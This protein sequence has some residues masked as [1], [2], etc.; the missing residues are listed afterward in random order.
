MTDIKIK[1]HVVKELPTERPLEKGAVYK[2]EQPNGDLLTYTIDSSGEPVLER[3]ITN[4]QN[5]RLERM[6]SEQISKVESITTGDIDKLQN[7]DSQQEIDSKFNTKV[8]KESGKSLVSDSEIDKLENLKSQSEIDSD[9]ATATSNASSQL[10]VVSG[11]VL[12]RGNDIPEYITTTGKAEL[13]GGNDT[14]GKTFTN[15]G[16][17]APDNTFNVPKGSVGYAYYDK[18][19]DSWSLVDMGELPQQDISGF[20]EKGGYEG[21]AQ[22]LDDRID[23]LYYKI[24]GFSDLEIIDSVIWND[25]IYNATTNTGGGSG[26][27]L[28]TYRY[29]DPIDISNIDSIDLSGLANMTGFNTSENR[30][31]TW[32]LLDGDG[33]TIKQGGAIVTNYSLG[34][35]TNGQS[36]II[37]RSN[38]SD[39]E[40]LY[41]VIT[42]FTA[43]DTYTPSVKVTKAKSVASSAELSALSETVQDNTDNIDNINIILEGVKDKELISI[44]A[45]WVAGIRNADG[46]LS[47]NGPQSAQFRN[48]SFDVSIYDQIYLSGLANITSYSSGGSPKY[49]WTL[50]DG[51]G[52]FIAGAQIVDGGSRTLIM[53]DYSQHAVKILHV[54]AYQPTYN[55]TY[56]PSVI[57]NKTGIAAGGGDQI[58][59]RIWFCGDSLCS[60][61]I[62][63]LTKIAAHFDYEVVLGATMGG[64][65]TIGNLTRSGGIPARINTGFTIPATTTAVPID[66]VSSWIKSDNNYAPLGIDSMGAGT[67]TSRV[68]I[69]G[70]QGTLAKVSSNIVGLLLYNSNQQLI[71]VYSGEGTINLV[72]VFYIRININNPQNSVPHVT[73][74]GVPVEDSDPANIPLDI[75]ELCEFTGYV[76][77]TNS[78]V[79]NS[80]YLRSD[81]IAVPPGTTSI[82]FDGLAVAN[83]YT[84]TRLT[85]GEELKVGTGE[86]LIFEFFYLYK[87]YPMIV[88]TGQN[89]GYENETDLVE[90]I[91]AATKCFNKKVILNTYLSRA[92]MEAQRLFTKRFGMTFINLRDYMQTRSVGDA[93]QFGL[94]DDTSQQADWMSL[95]LSDNVHQMP[96]GGFVQA[97][98]IW[99][100]L[101]ELGYVEGDY[102]SD[103]NLY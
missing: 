53:S 82:Y 37:D 27:Q 72:D 95:L 102:V 4:E 28:D 13:L 93:I 55:D 35:I 90:Q 23:D 63:Q 45:T 103:G 80:A 91:N 66:L 98:L 60:A 68:R 5:A 89:G 52:D 64:E 50:F 33:V 76:S 62:A 16:K 78:V 49:T 59:K 97:V 74:L 32:V 43:T 83:G 11:T 2:V 47:N 46:G 40:E 34:N 69:K 38:Y 8:D 94:I 51:S 70:V 17:P 41:L 39:I 54:N 19:S 79:S 29:S 84:F 15:T 57:A 100:R 7:L 61:I 18:A 81:F 21:T 67:I 65:Q 6:S 85:A 56:T 48:T 71:S 10:I 73:L 20:T 88:L 14:G 1:T 77:N 12:P 101:V 42:R 36:H 22:D 30:R 58:A 25:G 99:N 26:P 3:G 96:E 44:D 31:G 87:D 86:P 75:L 92:N 9:I 24:D